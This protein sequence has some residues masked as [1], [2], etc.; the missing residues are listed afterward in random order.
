MLSYR[1]K[2]SINLDKNSKCII[3]IHGYGSNMD[4]LFSFANYLPDCFTVIS[5]HAPFNTPFGGASWYSINFDSNSEKWI[6]T[7]EALKSLE[8]IINQLEYFI[9]KYE[10]DPHDICL[11]GFSQG[12][13]LSWTLLL[14]YPSLFRRAICMSGYI[15][16][17]L[18]QHPLGKYRNIL[19]YSSHGSDDLMIPHELAKSGVEFLKKNNPDVTFNT[20]PDGH[21]VSQ[22][23]FESILNWI[24]ETNLSF[25]R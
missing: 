18:L 24:R 5:L 3:M 2:K 25:D 10:L 17:K 19:A 12:A 4:D 9:S 11:M 21:N 8:R 13:V 6:N 15:D 22:E 23:N 20:Y 14:D 16:K 1:I 7:K